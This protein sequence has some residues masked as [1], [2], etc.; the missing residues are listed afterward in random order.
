MS[1]ETLKE[2]WKNFESNKKCLTTD[3]KKCTAFVKKIKSGTGWSRKPDDVVKDVASLNLSRY[4][5]EVVQGVLEARPKVT[6]IPVII[7]LTIA[8][9]SDTLNLY[10]TF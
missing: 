10:P 9:T 6:D 4:V 3:L 5:E 2:S 7:A 8:F 1:E